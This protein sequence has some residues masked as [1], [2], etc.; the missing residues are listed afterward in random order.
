[1]RVEEGSD[2]LLRWL[3]ADPVATHAELSL[4][5]AESE[6]EWMGAAET[7]QAVVDSATGLASLVVAVAAWRDARRQN[8]SR[9]PPP[10][11]HIQHGAV[12][13]E[14]TDDDPAAV[15]RIIDALTAVDGSGTGEDSSAE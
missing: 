10:V 12:S 15:S 14:I 6:Q 4:P 13:V 1:M 3:R 9:T 7:V 8:P 11:V 2:D 5:K